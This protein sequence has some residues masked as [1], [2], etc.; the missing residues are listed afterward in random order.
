[1]AEQE[2]W[3]GDHVLESAQVGVQRSRSAEDETLLQ[4]F[5]DASRFIGDARSLRL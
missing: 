5:L 1:V 2:D 3:G 4:T